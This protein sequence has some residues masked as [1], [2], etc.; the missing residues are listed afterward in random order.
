MEILILKC[1]SSWLVKEIGRL[2]SF[3]TQAIG[4]KNATILREIAMKWCS[5]LYEGLECSQGGNLI[6]LVKQIKPDHTIMYAEASSRMQKQ[7]NFKC[8]QVRFETKL[9]GI[10]LELH[11]VLIKRFLLKAF[12]RKQLCS[13]SR[14]YDICRV[15]L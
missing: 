2:V 5:C 1:S 15:S 11:L 4:T 7:Q 3:I 6:K 12:L 8:L 14:Q 13:M 10:S 9:P